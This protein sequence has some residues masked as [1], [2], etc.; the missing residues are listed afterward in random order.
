M[1]KIC[2]YGGKGVVYP[3]LGL[4]CMGFQ[5]LHAK[6]GCEKM[7]NLFSQPLPLSLLLEASFRWTV[8]GAPKSRMMVPPCESKA[9]PRKCRH[10]FFF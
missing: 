9:K 6:W 1:K 10:H 2:I 8:A 4:L 5:N 7:Q 3:F